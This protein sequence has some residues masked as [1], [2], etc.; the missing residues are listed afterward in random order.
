M[1]KLE[2]KLEDWVSTFSLS[3][4][5][6][7]EIAQDILANPMFVSKTDTGDGINFYSYSQM[8]QMFVFGFNTNKPVIERKQRDS[9]FSKMRTMQKGDTITL[10]YEKWNAART[11]A[12]KLKTDYGVR[13]KVN[14]K[15]IDDIRQIQVIRVE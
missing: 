13:F 3:E 1:N 14:V 8:V 7:Q 6:I 4:Q 15:T 5:E 9:A 2:K 10:P 11:S 12:S